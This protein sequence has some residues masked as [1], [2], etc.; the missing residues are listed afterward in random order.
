MC[1][2]PDVGYGGWITPPSTRTVNSHTITIPGLRFTRIGVTDLA[3]CGLLVSGKVTCWYP[4]WGQ[5]VYPGGKFTQMSVGNDLSG[6]FCGLRSSG[7]GVCWGD[8]EHLAAQPPTTK[9]QQ[10]AAGT[11]AACGIEKNGTTVQCWGS[12]DVKIRNG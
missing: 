3:V 5:G 4:S 1:W 8:N 9:F 10:I 12:I 6:F 2:G 11:S 7:A